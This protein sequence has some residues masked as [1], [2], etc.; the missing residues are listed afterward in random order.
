[1][2]K[3]I[4]QVLNDE[5]DFLVTPFLVRPHVLSFLFIYS[6]LKASKNNRSTLIHFM[7]S[8]S[9]LNIKDEDVLDVIILEDNTV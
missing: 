5:E 3:S 9:W 2:P 6:P 1:M 4:V 7:V 8:L